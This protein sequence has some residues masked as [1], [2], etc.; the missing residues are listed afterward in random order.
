MTSISAAMSQLRHALEGLVAEQAI[1]R[2]ELQSIAQQ[3]S[4][5]RRDGLPAGRTFRANGV[6]AAG[7]PKKRGRAFKFTDAQATDIRKRVEGGTSAVALAKELK[8]SL[9]TLYNTLKRAGWAGRHGRPAGRRSRPVRAATGAGGPKKRG[10][11]FKFSDD[12]AAE[13]RKQVEGGK[14]ALALAKELKISLPTMY[15]TLKRAGWSG[16]RGRLAGRTARAT[17]GRAPGGPKKRGRAF[18]FTDAQAAELKKQVDGGKSALALAKE[19]KISLPTMY[20]TLKRA[21]WKGTR[22]RKAK[23]A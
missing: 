3:G 5:V 13:F 6:G 8:I 16:R 22:G 4:S 1:L 14:R 19:L 20:N 2:R 18:K 12:Q 7:R 11:A 21:G 15:N 17:N 10:R 23:A 9:P